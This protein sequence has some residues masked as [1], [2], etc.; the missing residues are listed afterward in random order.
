MYINNIISYVTF[1]RSYALRGINY[2]YIIYKIYKIIGIIIIK[3]YNHS[4]HFTYFEPD[5]S[6]FFHCITFTV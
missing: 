4:Y 5:C 1:T 2:Y 6:I 3:D